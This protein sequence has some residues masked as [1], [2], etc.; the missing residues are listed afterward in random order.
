MKSNHKVNH[1]HKDLN[2]KKYEIEYFTNS[3]GFRDL[4]LS[5]FVKK[6]RNEKL[7]IFLGGSSALG[8][9]T[10]NYYNVD[11]ILERKLNQFDSEYKYKVLNLSI[12]GGN[13]YQS[14]LALDLY[15][16]NLD[17]DYIILSDGRNDGFLSFV[18]GYGPKSYNRYPS[19][20]FYLNNYFFNQPLPSLSHSSI[21]NF[22]LKYSR[23]VQITTGKKAC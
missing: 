23:L 4:E 11:E 13:A 3:D 16:K 21:L 15:A 1:I 9:G 10:S 14:F 20:S 8:V 2:N 18:H 7:V 6:N 19:I 5:N 17:P 12:G 22:L